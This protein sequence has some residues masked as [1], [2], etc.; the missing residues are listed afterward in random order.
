MKLSLFDMFAPHYCFSCGE[1]GAVLCVNCKNNIVS[2]SYSACLNCGKLAMPQA[3]LCAQ[4]KMEFSRAWC[5]GEREDG[6]KNLINHYKF[7]RAKAAHLLIAE[8]LDFALPDLPQDIFVTSVPTISSHIR[9]RGYDHAALMAR[10]FAK[11]RK[12]PYRAT[13][14]RDSSAVQHGATRQERLRQAKNAFTCEAV[15]PKIYLLIDD[16]YTTGATMN[17]TA[18]SLKDAG[19]TE[20]WAAVVARQPDLRATLL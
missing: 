7:N 6:L 16:I 1:I 8:L 10:T 12:L 15:A 3:G 4:C 14:R 19:A 9:Q 2:E 18:K 13:V 20:V 5:V 11:I 17:Y